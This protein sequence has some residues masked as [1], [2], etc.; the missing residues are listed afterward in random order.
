MTDV[1][2]Y[3]ESFRIGGAEKALLTLLRNMDKQRFRVH[4][5]CMCR[6]GELLDQYLSVPGINIRFIL[7]P[8]K[9]FVNSVKSKLLY[10]ILPARLS[11]SLWGKSHSDIEV[12]FC[13][14]FT[15]RLL[16]RSTNRKAKRVAWV[17]TDLACNDWPVKQGIFRDRTQEIKAYSKFNTVVCVSENVRRGIVN[18]FGKKHCITVYNPIEAE[19]I[20]RGCKSS[21]P[22]PDD[23]I[24]IVSIGRLEWLK[25]YDILID[26]FRH[27][28]SDRRILLHMVG[29]GSEYETLKRQIGKYGL[30]KRIFLHG[31]Q[32]N[33]YSYLNGADIYVC[34]SRKEGFNIAL[35]EA[36]TA[37]VPVVATHSAGPQE[38]IGNNEYGIICDES[39]LP[40][41]IQY[42]ID[43]QNERKRL[44]G[45]A[46][47]RAGHF[48]LEKSMSA[49]HKLLETT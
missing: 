29:D 24:N 17:H 39:A 16:S 8:C 13:E 42:L 33:P 28:K 48:A 11:Y 26:A 12:A 5:V 2:F 45:A 1:T 4:V 47:L 44:S 23:A 38:I 49:I 34:P 18:E 21:H 10:R 15:T 20:R 37:A 3:T 6:T 9:G 25:G 43:H 36:M 41:K 32:H 14:G 46:A 40:E 30:D 19:E 31:M 35:I 22:L 27:L 7:D